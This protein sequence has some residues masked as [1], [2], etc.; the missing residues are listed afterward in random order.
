MPLALRHAHT[1]R[2]TTRTSTRRRRRGRASATHTPSPTSS[3]PN[4][5]HS[6][7]FPVDAPASPRGQG[8]GDGLPHL[9][10]RV[11]LI[12]LARPPANHRAQPPPSCPPRHAP[13]PTPPRASP[14]P[15]PSPHAPVYW[16][17]THPSQG[18]LHSHAMTAAP[19]AVAGSLE[20]EE[21]IVRKTSSRDVCESPQSWICK[22]SLLASMASKSLSILTS[23]LST[24]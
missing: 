2:H 10:E 7:A 24:W 14:P 18:A 21:T 9:T 17:G 3:K 6:H 15:H 11:E 8:R 12:A 4:H 16:Q 1:T 19:T 5:R 23:A 20:V 22:A 13:R